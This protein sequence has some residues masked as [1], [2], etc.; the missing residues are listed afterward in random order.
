MHILSD[1]SVET[2]RYIVSARKYRPATF[3]SVVGQKNLTAT[4]KN[5]IESRR[6]A[7]AYLFCGP[8]GV[9]KTS[10]ARIF[11]RTINCLS[12]T[13]DGEACGEC[14]SC[15][16]M[17]EGN[18]FNIIELD[19]ASNNSVED[20]RALTEQVNVPPQIGKYRVFIIDEVHMLSSSA[21]NAFL[22]TLEE[23]PGY[24]IF[25]LATTEKHKVLPTI[26]SRCQIYDFSRITVEDMTEH[27]AYVAGQ[28]GI[29]AEPA[30]LNVIARKADGAMR[31]ALS[32]FDQVAASTRGNLT[33][34]DTIANLNVLDY[35]YYFRLIDKFRS[36]DIPE[37]LLIYKEIL[38]KGFDSLFFIEG[39]ASHVRDLMVAADPKTLS[40]LEVSQD[41]AARYGEQARTLPVEWYYAALKILND[42]SVNLRTSGNKRLLAEL[43]LIRL[44]QLLK[45]STPPF[46]KGETLPPLRD[47]MPAQ[48]KGDSPVVSHVAASGGPTNIN[49]GN[50][51][52]AKPVVADYGVSSQGT[53]AADPGASVPKTARPASGQ[54]QSSLRMR[55]AATMH[56]RPVTG[57]QITEVSNQPAPVEKVE[58]RSTPID[59]QGFMAAW[60]NFMINNPSMHILLSAMRTAH[61][62]RIDATT[63]AIKVNHP[64]GIQAL[65]SSMRPLISYLRDSLQND[66]L[67]LKPELDDTPDPHKKLAPVDFL[68]K[69]VEGNQP[70]ADFLARIDAEIS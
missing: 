67:I 61:I 35:D 39:L 55:S 58:N 41:V 9:G 26:L 69:I 19:A 18:S 1:M 47:P 36:S 2:N 13:A 53:V 14:A 57:I 24:V 68:K 63:F 30:A 52:G 42:A 15:K 8:R 59:E 54:P 22:K 70:L 31:D 46:D 48:P 20:I 3:K 49:A 56:R 32:I 38:D 62:S 28:E 23:P 5:A 11:A 34:G 25:I 40:L 60:N 7:Q 44:C 50:P 17:E 4:L 45:P 10:C 64:A 37:S 29:A 51:A 43:T 27:L 6:L 65:E 21:F 12:P 66:F 33:Y 16:A